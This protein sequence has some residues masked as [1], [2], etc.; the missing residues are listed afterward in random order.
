MPRFTAVGI[1][2]LVAL[3]RATTGQP[4]KFGETTEVT[5]SRNSES[6]TDAPASISVVGQKHI[7]TSPADNYGDLLRGVPGLNVVQTS[8]RDIGIRARGASGVA[9]HREVVLLDG[10]SLYLD[11]Y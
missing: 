2:L 3:A 4:A 11:F 1:V 9:E 8:A 7:E 5:A 6:I 10:R